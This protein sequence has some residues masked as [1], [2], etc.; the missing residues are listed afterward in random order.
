MHGV[1]LA[2][3]TEAVEAKPADAWAPQAEWSTTPVADQDLP[4][5]TVYDNAL[6][7]VTIDEAVP[8]HPP[9]VPPV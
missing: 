4:D 6:E 9:L 7:P 3:A 2:P 1:G 8:D 5:E